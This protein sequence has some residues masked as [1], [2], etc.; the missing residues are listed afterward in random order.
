LVIQTGYAFENWDAE[1]IRKIGSGGS[2]IAA[3]RMAEE[4]VGLGYRVVVFAQ[5]GRENRIINEVEWI[6][7]DKWQEFIDTNYIDICIIS[8]YANF[9]ETSIRAGKIYL[10]LHDIWAMCSDMNGVD[11]VQKHYNR[12][13]GIFVLSNWHKEFVCQHHKIRPDRII[14]T[15]NGIDLGRFG[16]YG[17]R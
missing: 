5:T 13:N 2:E 17:A 16:V 15:G 6:N 8:R 14:I 4:F 1:V 7:S 3:C 12:L 11:L 10:W 9:L